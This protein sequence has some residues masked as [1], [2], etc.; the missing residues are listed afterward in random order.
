MMAVLMQPF[1]H[2]G[3]TRCLS[4]SCRR[5]RSSPAGGRGAA[6]AHMRPVVS[7]ALSLSLVL[8]LALP[9]H[10]GRNLFQSTIFPLP[11]SDFSLAL[12]LLLFLIRGHNFSS[13]AVAARSKM[14][15]QQAARE[16]QQEM[17]VWR[18]A[19]APAA[20]L[21]LSIDGYIIA[22]IM[23]G[24]CCCWQ[25]S[26]STSGFYFILLAASA[27]KSWLGSNRILSANFF[28]AYFDYKRRAFDFKHTRWG[29]NLESR[30]KLLFFFLWVES[31]VYW[32]YRAKAFFNLYTASEKL[33]AGRTWQKNI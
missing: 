26:N 14:K 9:A 11:T 4:Q 28:C 5:R 23:F 22:C 25:E 29:F 27:G 13:L 2:T 33:A 30:R 20:R 17:D 21:L 10:Y 12:S 15:Y 18:G 1:G 16:R 19:A 3:H 6:A 24:C 32:F 31:V 7:P 8:V